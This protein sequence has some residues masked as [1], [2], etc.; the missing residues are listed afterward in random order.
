MELHQDSCV[1]GYHIYNDIWTSVLKEVLLTQRELHNVIDCYAIAV[2]NHSG[3]TI[4]HLPRKISRLCSMFIDQD[5]DI[6]CVVTN[7]RRYSSNL[8]QGGLAI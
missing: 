1:C 3:D 6:T 7:S 8:V 2:K 4:G 5:G